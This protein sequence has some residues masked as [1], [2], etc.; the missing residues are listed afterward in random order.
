VQVAV[1]ECVVETDA[2]AAP[3][4]LDLVRQMELPLVL[5]FNAGAVD[6]LPQ[7]TSKATGLNTALRALRL[8]EHN[9]LAIGNAENDHAMLT[10]CEVGV[11]VSWG[12]P[13]LQEVADEVIDGDGPA[14]VAD[15]LRRLGPRLKMPTSGLDRH[16]VLLGAVPSG[17]PSAWPC[18][19]ETSWS[20]ATQARGN[21][22]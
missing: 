14:A 17:T 11:A 2:S 10:A 7:G 3:V 20:R 12:G 6:G 4:V 19:A 1:G 8:S 16:R 5:A 21:P 22:G 15:Y 18:V 13:A 9:A